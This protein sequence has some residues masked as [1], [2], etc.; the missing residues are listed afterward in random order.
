MGTLCTARKAVFKILARSGGQ[1]YGHITK[2]LSMEAL[3][4]HP[5]LLTVDAKFEAFVYES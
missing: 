4:A 3:R 2:Q 1:W 5:C